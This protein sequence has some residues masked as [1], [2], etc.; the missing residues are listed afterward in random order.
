VKHSPSIVALS[1]AWCACWLM[2]TVTG[3]EE[4]SQKLSAKSFESRFHHLGA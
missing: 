1:G 2:E 3:A 4:S